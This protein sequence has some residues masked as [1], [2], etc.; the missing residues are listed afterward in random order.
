[1]VYLNGVCALYTDVG[2]LQPNTAYTL[3]VSV[4]LGDDGQYPNFAGTIGLV[5][6]TTDTGTPLVTT[7]V[8]SGFNETNYIDYTATF[9]TGG[10]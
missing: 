2:A 7:A 4:G 9:A 5:N 1:V 6:G 8:S 3:R 10:A